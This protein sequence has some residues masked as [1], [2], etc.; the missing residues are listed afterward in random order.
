MNILNVT[1]DAAIAQHGLQMRQD[2]AKTASFQDMLEQAAASQDSAELRRA[3]VEF[4]SY[5]TQ[6]MFKEMRKTVPTEN[7]LFP[8][9]NAET[10]FQD[11]LDEEYAKRAAQAG[12][13]GLA[14]MLYRQLSGSHRLDIRG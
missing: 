3:C 9:S 2:E 6:L 11:M 14:D 8:K 12:G 13:I 10:I 7:S 4:E 5:F 1:G